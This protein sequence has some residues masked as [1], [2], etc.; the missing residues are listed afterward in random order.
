MKLRSAIKNDLFAADRRR[1]KIDRMGDPLAHIAS[2]CW[3]RRESSGTASGEHARWPATVPDRDHG[4]Y[5]GAQA[6]VQPVGRSEAEPDKRPAFLRS[7]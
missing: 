1:G 4:A 7:G 5:Q 2:W 6:P 3:R